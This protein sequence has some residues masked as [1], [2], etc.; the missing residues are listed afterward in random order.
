MTATFSNEGL[1][2]LKR[3]TLMLSTIEDMCNLKKKGH[4]RAV[5]HDIQAH[6]DLNH[7]T[8]TKEG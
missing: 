1:G 7:D 5:S 6:W 4:L 8:E 2:P 3:Q